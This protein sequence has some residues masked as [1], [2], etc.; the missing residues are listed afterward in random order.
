MADIKT[1]ILVVNRNRLDL[2]KLCLDSLLKQTVPFALT[3]VDN[4]SDDFGDVAQVFDKYSVRL[5]ERGNIVYTERLAKNTPLNHLWNDLASISI[6]PYL[7]MLN[8]DVIVPDNFVED[9]EKLLAHNG[10][11]GITCHVTNRPLKKSSDLSYIEIVN[12][13]QGW[14]FTIR[15][16][17]YEPIPDELLWLCGDDWLFHHV[18]KKG[19]TIGIID[20]SPIIHFQG[21]APRPKPLLSYG[22]LTRFRAMGIPERKKTHQLGHSAL[23]PC[24]NAVL[25][26][27]PWREI[28]FCEPKPV[29]TVPMGIIK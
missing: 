14:D 28:G 17:A 15:R 8:N 3:I 25:C 19:Y 4:N 18:C 29:E 16:E 24:C 13:L 6:Y 26:K 9:S 20:S 11:V 21:A 7:C 2:T 5:R 1:H 27:A 10:R 22:D 12:T 23:K